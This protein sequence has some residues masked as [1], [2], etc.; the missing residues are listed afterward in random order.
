MPTTSPYDMNRSEGKLQ[1]SKQSI[2]QTRVMTSM[3]SLDA[4]VRA[5]NTFFSTTL[6]RKKGLAA[7][8]PPASAAPAA[9]TP[10]A[11]ATGPAA[12]GEPC[13]PVTGNKGTR[14]QCVVQRVTG[15]CGQ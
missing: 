11:T 12:A 7:S 9:A 15:E 6:W 13:K 3:G 4:G 8:P 1:S 14:G 10:P 5:T 2:N